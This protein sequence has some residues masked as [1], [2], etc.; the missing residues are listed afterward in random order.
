MRNTSVCFPPIADISSSALARQMAFA[1]DV[2]LTAI[3]LLVLADLVSGMARGRLLLLDGDR[4][5]N[6]T[7]F[8]VCAGV[9]AILVAL[10]ASFWF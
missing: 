10:V 9:E 2:F 4:T 1:L 7:T 8:W 6:R 5:V 3:A